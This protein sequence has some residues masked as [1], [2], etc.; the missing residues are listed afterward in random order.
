MSSR[1][2]FAGNIRRL[3]KERDRSD[4]GLDTVDRYATALGVT[5]ACLLTP[6]E[7]S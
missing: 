7:G 1:E 3:R 2:V 5:A 6:L 4:P